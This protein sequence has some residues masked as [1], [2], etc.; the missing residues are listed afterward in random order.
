MSD[1]RLKKDI[2]LVGK[3]PKGVKIYNFKFIY[4]YIHERDMLIEKE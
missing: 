4:K 1:I 2:K 3:S